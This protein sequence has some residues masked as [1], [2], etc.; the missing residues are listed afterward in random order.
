M[1]DRFREVSFFCKDFQRLNNEQQLEVQV[2]RWEYEA[3]CWQSR[4]DAA[5]QRHRELEAENAELKAKLTQIRHFFQH[6]AVKPMLRADF[7]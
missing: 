3:R 2:R 5:K 4:F 7:D 6:F 1:P